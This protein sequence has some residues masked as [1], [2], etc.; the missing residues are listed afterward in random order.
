MTEDRSF[1]SMIVQAYSQTVRDGIKNVFFHI[2]KA[3][4]GRTVSKTDQQGTLLTT[5]NM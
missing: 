1:R 4:K 2:K 3:T 5:L